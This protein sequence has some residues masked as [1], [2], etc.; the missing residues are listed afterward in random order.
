MIEFVKHNG[1]AM[2][3]NLTII[4]GLV[5]FGTMETGHNVRNNQESGKKNTGKL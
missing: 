1:A 2:G 5:S 3:T 4:E